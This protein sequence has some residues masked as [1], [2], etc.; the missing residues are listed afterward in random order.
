MTSSSLITSHLRNHPEAFLRELTLKSMA[1]K[2]DATL[3]PVVRGLHQTQLDDWLTFAERNLVAPLVAH[4]MI[5]ANITGPVSVRARALHQQSESRMDILMDQL[6]VTAQRL[7]RAG[8]SL[9]ALKNAGIARGIYPCRACCPMGDIDVLVPREQF[10]DAHKLVLESGFVIATRGTVEGTDIDAAY[11]S[12][13]AE[14]V[15]RAGDTDVWLELQWRPVAGRWI[16]PEQ[17]PDGS[18]LV[19]RSV[20]IPGTAARLLSPEDNM[21]QVALHTAKH[22]FVRAPGLRLHTDVDRLASLAPPDWNKVLSL[23]SNLDIRTACYFSLALARTLLSS[24]VPESVLSPLA[25]APWKQ[26]LIYRWLNHVD[27]FNPEDVKFSR[28]SMMIFHALLYDD[29]RLLAASSLDTPVEEL[30]LRHLPRNVITGIQ[31]IS[32]IVVRYQH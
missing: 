7:D 17:E 30:T 11:R 20:S 24:P 27:L 10:F 32:D 28:P 31:R 18:T 1:V 26:Q 9:V 13:G 22:S 29:A 4:T 16:R 15:K 5:E 21:V 12:G 2:K 14:Y 3:V 6:D 19:Q 25:P 8:I 23:V